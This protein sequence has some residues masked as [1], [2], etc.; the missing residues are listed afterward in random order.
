MQ[1]LKQTYK[2]DWIDIVDTISDIGILISEKMRYYD[3]SNAVYVGTN[4]F[5]NECITK[6][7][8][9]A[10]KLF[11][12]RLSR[13]VCVQELISEEDH[14]IIKCR[15]DAQY[16]VAYDPIDGSSNSDY[17]IPVGSIFGIYQKQKLIVSG[18]IIYGASTILVL[19]ASQVDLYML[20]QNN[21]WILQR[22]NI[23][24]KPEAN[25]YSVN[26]GNCKN[27]DDEMQNYMKYLKTTRSDSLRY[28]GSMVADI[29]RTLLAGGIFMYPADIKNTSGKLR[30][31]YEVNP[32]SHI[33]ETAGGLS[34][35]D[36]DTRCLDVENKHIHQ[37]C[38][39]FAGSPIN[40]EHYLQFNSTDT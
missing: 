21:E 8:D 30:L 25:I 11:H 1:T 17:N 9:Y 15:T 20:D 32:M 34:Y 40:V 13:L 14:D 35:S 3:V 5:H 38:P 39:I 36:R 31:L 26:E 4:N 27:W 24:I 2:T 23:K 16:T 6:L 33:I 29:H 10:N 37:R 12:E 7:D 19:A 18:Y 28:V 22:S